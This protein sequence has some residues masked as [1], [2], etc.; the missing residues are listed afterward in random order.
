MEQLNGLYKVTQNHSNHGSMVINT[1]GMLCQMNP[2]VLFLF[3]S[4]VTDLQ[5]TRVHN[6]E[7]M[8]AVYFLGQLYT[9]CKTTD[10]LIQHKVF[11]EHRAV[12]SLMKQ[13]VHNQCALQIK[14]LISFSSTE[15]YKARTQ[16]TA[17]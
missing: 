6:T 1:E 14:G 5:N 4:V 10:Y 3:G 17:M 15:L 2:V 11:W 7:F 13:K 12:P 9:I 8:P 16:K